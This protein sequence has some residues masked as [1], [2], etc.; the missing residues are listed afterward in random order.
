MPNDLPFLYELTAIGEGAPT[1]DEKCQIVEA[2]REHSPEFGP[3]LDRFWIEHIA[4]LG[5]D[6]LEAQKNQEELKQVLQKLTAD[7]WHSAIFLSPVTTSKGRRAVVAY[8]NS[9]RVVGFATTVRVL[10]QYR[11]D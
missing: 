6:L 1:V 9:Q 10:I 5:T 7:P 2:I 4:S 8:A 11:Y 3:R